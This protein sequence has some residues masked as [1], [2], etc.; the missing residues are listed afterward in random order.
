M[1][2]YGGDDPQWFCTAVE[3]ILK[4]NGL[5]KDDVAMMF[6]L[7]YESE[8]GRVVGYDNLKK[9][10]NSSQMQAMIFSSVNSK[11]SLSSAI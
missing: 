4:K 1:C 7:G 6:E 5:S 2:V 10:K 11:S 3:S 9:L 8:L